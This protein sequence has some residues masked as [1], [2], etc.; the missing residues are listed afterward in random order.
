[1]DFTSQ[2]HYYKQTKATYQNVK[3]S[4]T[5]NREIRLKGRTALENLQLVNQ[6]LLRF[7][8]QLQGEQNLP[9]D[10]LDDTKDSPDPE[11]I[12]CKTSSKQVKPANLGKEPT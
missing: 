5:T 11:Q 2:K 10:P 7:K 6:L 12:N 4:N 8:I 3:V 9:T 1:M